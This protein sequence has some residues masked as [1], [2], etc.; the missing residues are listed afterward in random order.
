MDY[1]ASKARTSVTG[2]GRLWQEAVQSCFHILSQ[3]FHK[4]SGNKIGNVRVTYN[5]GAFM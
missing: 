1:L 4:E 3:H 5:E 2:M